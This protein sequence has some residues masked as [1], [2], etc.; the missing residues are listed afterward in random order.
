MTKQFIAALAGVGL[1]AC[2]GDGG[3]D[4]IRPPAGGVTQQDASMGDS[5]T[6]RDD[7][8]ATRDECTAKEDCNGDLVCVSGQCVLPQC[9]VDEE[10]ADTLKCV[11]FR[12]RFVEGSDSGVATENTD[13][14]TPTSV[15]DAGMA[16]PNADPGGEDTQGDSADA[17]L[18]ELVDA[19]PDANPFDFDSSFRQAGGQASTGGMST[20]EPGGQ[21]AAGGTAEPAGAVPPRAGAS[22][23]GDMDMNPS[24]GGSAQAALAGTP[25]DV[26][27]QPNQGGSPSAG[28][29]TPTPECMNL[30][31]CALNQ[32]CQDGVCVLRCDVPGGALCGEG[33]VCDDASGECVVVQMCNPAC[34]DGSECNGVD[35]RC[36]GVQPGDEPCDGACPTGFICHEPSDTCQIAA[37]TE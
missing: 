7:Q 4:P 24:S 23:M 35:G 17:G 18:E 22:N 10:C 15:L 8:S 14:T 16:P 21:P 12:C 5:D 3:T 31:D 19:S 28:E 32:R 20:N 34:G 29:T 37:C 11:E 26:A 1:L 36:V 13:G 2:G 25:A 30:F 6:N 9:T 33:L 27:G